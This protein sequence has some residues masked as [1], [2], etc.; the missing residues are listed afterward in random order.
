MSVGLLLLRVVVGALFVGHGAQKL[1][2]WFGGHGLRG[3]ATFMESLGFRNGRMA[4]VA[5]GLAETVGGLLLACGLLT[6]LGAAAIVGVMVTAALCVHLRNGLWNASGGVE[7]PLVYATAAAALALAG[8]GP[9][10]L[11]RVLG[12]DLAGP[13]YGLGAL[14]LGTLTGLVAAGLR[15]ATVPAA[16][17]Q[18]EGT[19]RVAA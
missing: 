7:L 2:G 9:F 14:A 3:T 1:F 19:E 8:P 5:A 4:A 18:P 13:W 16:A 11:D 6:P 17:S 10:S 12:L 15:R